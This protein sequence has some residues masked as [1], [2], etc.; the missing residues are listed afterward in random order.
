MTEG[1]IQRINE[2]AKK[3]KTIGLTEQEKKEREELRKQYLLEF[4]AGMQ[5]NILDNLYIVDENGNK[6][7]VSKNKK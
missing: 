7:K 1:L 3:A 6:T 5:K 4:R 2:I